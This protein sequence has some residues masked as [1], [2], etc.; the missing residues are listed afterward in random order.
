MKKTLLCLSLIIFL[1]SSCS[2]ST[3]TTK[4]T[5]LT[6]HS[7]E[8][9]TMQIPAN[10]IVLDKASRTIPSPKQW[11]V[12]LAVT[13]SEAVNGFSNNLVVLQNTLNYET[14]SKN[15]SDLNNI[16]ASEDYYSYTLD[17]TK[18]LTFNDD[19]VSTLYSFTAQYSASTPKLRFL[20]TGRICE[21]KNSFFLTIALSEN[22]TDTAKYEDILKSFECK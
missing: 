22:I 21:K 9:F 7:E 11:S 5:G 1:L 18:D 3:P 2:D 14:T 4:T 12:A 20:Q 15:F 6:E 10:W 19:E 17:S 8:A 13:S 16:G